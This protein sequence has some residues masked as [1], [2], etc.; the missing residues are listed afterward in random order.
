MTKAKSKRKAEKK[1]S[2]TCPICGTMFY[3]WASQLK[4]THP[5]CSVACGNKVQSREGAARWGGGRKKCNGYILLYQ[6]E[7]PDC[8]A[9]G[10]IF[11]HRVVMEKSLRRRLMLGEHV[12]HKNGQRDD[13]RVDNLEILDSV[14]AHR[15]KH[16]RAKPCRRCGWVVP[17]TDNQLRHSKRCR[18]CYERL[19][20]FRLHLAN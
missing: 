19:R 8:Q 6:P 13:N 9:G 15:Y 18:A 11:E 17:Y 4:N 10:Y 12:H 5:A 20:H 16:Y 2:Y 1:Q 3:R 14:S 7:H